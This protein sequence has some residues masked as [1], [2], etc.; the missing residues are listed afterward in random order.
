[1]NRINYSNLVGPDSFIGRY[2]SFMEDQETAYSYD[3]WCAC[4]LLSL[5]L[6]RNVV[7]PRPRAPIFMNLYLLLIAESGVTRKSSA[8]R[9][10]TNIAREFIRR[11]D[12]EYEEHIDIIEAATTPEALET[13]LAVLSSDHGY[14]HCA[15]AVSELVTFLGNAGY[16][17]AMPGLLT[18]LYD[19]P[20][21]RLGGGTIKRGRTSI[22]NTFI[23]F[24]SA[25]TPSWLYRSV[26]PDVVEGGFTSRC[27]FIVS[28]QRKARIAWPEGV[29]DE[30]KFKHDTVQSLLDIRRRTHSV[31]SLKVSTSAL[32]TFKGWYSRKAE[33]VD[34]F[35][36]SFES[37]ED[38]H[39]LRLAGLL[40]VSEERWELV[41][42]DINKATRII[43]EVKDDGATIFEGTLSS[44]RFI[45]GIEKVRQKLL[46]AG[47]EGITQSM[48][49]IKTRDYISTNEL[50]TT[51]DIMHELGMVQQFLVPKKEKQRGPSQKVWRATKLMV[52]RGALE[53]VLKEI[54]GH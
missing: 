54:K 40:S 44:D 7:I 38:S 30:E 8:V 3:F 49:L 51:L 45:M 32:E 23:N 39:V 10:A 43:R 11:L 35:R 1:M 13:R 26:N 28:E 31:S 34:P 48:L 36:S 46:D 15:I 27:M 5:A 18:D 6:G 47:Q 20:T 53:E 52:T 33:S 42:D 2:M 37:R 9:M 25:S 29:K 22:K 19:S 16:S 17:M 50:N 4:W 12:E 24:V 14:A 41:P 21:L